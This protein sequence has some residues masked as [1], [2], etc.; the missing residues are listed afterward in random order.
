MEKSQYQRETRECSFTD[1]QPELV[2]AI[3]EYVQERE[4]E[5]VETELLICCETTSVRPERGAMAKLKARL[6]GTFDP[7][8]DHVHH[9][10]II[11][12]P[13]LLIWGTSGEKQGTTIL[14]ARLSMIEVTDYKPELID[15]SG[16]NIFG[17]IGRFPER[18][19]MFIGLGKDSAAERLKD[20]LRQAVKKART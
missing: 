14:S 3:K 17:E 5:D 7:A 6:L 20:V 13:R 15:D 18:A 10:G 12:T 9:T 2:S 8:P 11:V 16:I 4:L 19:S 1:L